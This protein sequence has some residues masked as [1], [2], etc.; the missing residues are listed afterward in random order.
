MMTLCYFG[1]RHV[2]LSTLKS[3]KYTKYNIFYWLSNTEKIAKSHKER[4]IINII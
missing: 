4:A 2:G 3:Y 1:L